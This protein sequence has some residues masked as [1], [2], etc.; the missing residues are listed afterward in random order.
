MELFIVIILYLVILIFQ[1]I[2]II[3]SKKKKELIAYS[4]LMISAAFLFIVK[5]VLKSQYSLSG[6][7][8]SVVF[9]LFGVK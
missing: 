9:N 6:Q 2:P 5:F 1:W 3:K 8:T 4:F 7:I